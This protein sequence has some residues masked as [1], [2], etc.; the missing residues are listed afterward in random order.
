MAFLHAKT[1]KSISE[2]QITHSTVIQEAKKKE[3][4]GKLPDFSDETYSFTQRLIGL[5]GN[6]TARDLPAAASRGDR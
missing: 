1:Q 6:K 4:S 3:K 2:W 5:R